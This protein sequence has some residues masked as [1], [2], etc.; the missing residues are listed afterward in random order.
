MKEV[1]RKTK[2]QLPKARLPR[3]TKDWYDWLRDR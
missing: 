3:T 1:K 2:Q